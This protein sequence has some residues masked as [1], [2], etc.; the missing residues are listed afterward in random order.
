MAIFK[1]LPHSHSKCGRVKII[2]KSGGELYK[3]LKD[4]AH[5]NLARILSYFPESQIGNISS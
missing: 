4:G 2:D 3:I 5:N 1:M